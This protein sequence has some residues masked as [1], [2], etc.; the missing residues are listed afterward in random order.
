[1]S[2]KS[3]FD[4]PLKLPQRP[5]VAPKCSGLA[6]TTTTPLPT[7]TRIPSAESIRTQLSTNFTVIPIFDHQKSIK[8]YLDEWKAAH[9]SAVFRWRL[10]FC[11]ELQFYQYQAP[12]WPYSSFLDENRQTWKPVDFKF[13]W[14]SKKPLYFS[15]TLKGEL[16]STNLWKLVFI[17]AWWWLFSIHVTTLGSVPKAH[18]SFPW[19]L[20]TPPPN[21][22]MKS[23]KIIQVW[24]SPRK[25]STQSIGKFG[26][27]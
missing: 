15:K 7:R 17:I 8:V 5:R 3:S 18:I 13:L 10:S 12:Y 16:K 1:M 6:V 4:W 24:P 2:R 11:P 21:S 27:S 22:V 19:H 9:K 14:F 25:F 23:I 26:I 20:L